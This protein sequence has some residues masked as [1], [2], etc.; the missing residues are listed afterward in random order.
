MILLRNTGKSVSLAQCGISPDRRFTFYDQIH[1]TGMDIKQAPN[2]RA[3]ITIGK[4]MTFRDYAQGAYRMRGIGLGQ[5]IQ[6]FIIPEVE[7]RMKEDLGVGL[8]SSSPVVFT[9]KPELDVPAW[10]LINSMRMESL[11]F[12][13]MSSQELFNLWRKRAL[14]TLVKEVQLNC[15]VGKQTPSFRLRRFNPEQSGESS[16]WMKKCIGLFREAVQYDIEDHVPVPHPYAAKLNELVQSNIDFVQDESEKQRV[17]NVITKVAQV[18]DNSS[19]AFKDTEGHGCNL[20]YNAEVVHENEQ[21]AEE[22]QEEEA[23]EEEQK[24]SAFN[25]DDEQANPWPA[26][27]LLEKPSGQVNGKDPFYLFS[28]FQVHNQHKPL[29]FPS[30]LLLSDNFFRPRWAG[31]GN[32]RLKNVCLVL[33]YLPTLWKE[34]LQ[35]QM[36]TRI[37][38]LFK[39]LTQGCGVSGC[40]NAQ[41]CASVKGL[42]PN[43]AAAKALQLAVASIQQQDE[44]VYCE[45]TKKMLAALP[46]ATKPNENERYVVAVSLA[47]GETI[48]RL[49]HLQQAGTLPSN[50]MKLSVALRALSGNVIDQSSNFQK[51]P[52]S[53][54]LVDVALQCLKF[55]NCEM[56]FTDNELT[57]LE[58]GLRLSNLD[59]RLAFFSESLR[60]RRRERNLWGDTPLAKIFTPQEEW[61]LLRSRATLEQFVHALGKAT[62]KRGVDAALSFLKLDSDNDG[63]LSE[64]ELQRCLEVLNLGFSPRDC[65]EIVRLAPFDENRKINLVAFKRFFNVSDELQ[66]PKQTKQSDQMMMMGNSWQCNNCSYINSVHN[67]TCLVCELGWTGRREC[68]PDKW[69]CAAEDGGCTF[70]NPKG[71]FYCE[72]CNKARPDLTTLRF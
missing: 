26:D 47:E 59:D 22:E 17:Q 63:C 25:R 13:K 29:S 35:D 43:A 52:E 24:V 1:T 31:L 62:K 50:L 5:T 61:H 68:P 54:S 48:R 7:N 19:S 14:N 39:Q 16:V 69:V 56:Y 23:E 55:F 21:E 33:E 38:V 49:L 27:Y 36:K 12:V 18:T 10:L 20:S 58:S 46:S 53:V 15:F 8:R 70:F 30:S 51:A 57:L 71:M 34:Q 2:A 11:Q 41:H 28:K 67:R 9:G 6:L 4:D 37:A 72:V 44:S 64:E 65:Y 45:A 60:L 32:R 66:K 42:D 3:V 40:T